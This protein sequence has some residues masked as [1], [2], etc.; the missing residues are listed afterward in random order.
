MLT[1][2]TTHLDYFKLLKEARRLD[3]STLRARVRVALLSDAS[4]QHLVPL[5]R[6]LLARAGFAADIYAAEFDTMD[7]EI[8][9][10]TSALHAFAPDFVVLLPAPRALAARYER[11]RG[12]RA[13]FGLEQAEHLVSLWD[14]VKSHSGATVLQVNHVVPA[15]G[16]F[17]SF[18]LCVPESLRANVLALNAALVTA[19]RKRSHVL[20]CDME[21]LASQIGKRAFVDDKLWAMAKL[22][23]ATEHL[24][25]VAQALVDVV[26]AARGRVVKCVVL[27]LDNTLWGGVIGDDGLT[28]ILIGNDGEGAA[29][30]AIQRFVRELGRRGIALAVCSKNQHDA[31]I[32]PFRQ[33]PD[34]TLREDDIAVFMA[35]WDTKVDNITRIKEALDIGFDAMVFLDDNPFE[36]NM[37]RQYLP[38]VT[39]PE[40]PADP[41]EWVAALTELN[42]FETTAHTSEDKARGRLYREEASRKVLARTFTSVEEYLTSLEMRVTFARFDAFHVPRIAQLCL[43]SNQF[44]LTTRRETEAECEALM[45]AGPDTWPVYLKLADRFG[46][47][48]LISVIVASFAGDSLHIDSWLMSCR[49]LSRGVEEY[50][51]NR[52]V[53]AA[54]ERGCAWVVGTYVP[55]AK[56]AMVRDFYAGFGFQK[57][58]EDPGG[59]TWKLRVEEYQPKG[60]ALTEENQE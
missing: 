32:L 16:V 29:F 52:M 5:L 13:S 18:A 58:G 48:G 44:N 6:V 35:N 26:V 45:T 39:V 34:M 46:D 57:A 15:D 50:A 31:A 41:S 3:V 37:V 10:P 54:R 24:P 56:N 8:L 4:T 7:T 49:V 2:D 9:D 53:A 60:H 27:D 55:T 33:H 20:L 14:A 17:G 23:A 28:G 25:R 51:M 47:A 12:D 1:A 40:L 59:V 22:Y 21:S 43:R 19:A 36:R 38:D 42:L 11:A 30:S